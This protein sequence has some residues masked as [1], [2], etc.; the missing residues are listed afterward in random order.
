MCLRLRYI[1]LELL[2][3]ACRATV[4]HLQSSLTKDAWMHAEA[5]PRPAPPRVV[6]GVL[7]C[8]YWLHSHAARPLALPPATSATA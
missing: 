1:M 4:E 6:V 7:P 2:K 3:N 8:G 5:R